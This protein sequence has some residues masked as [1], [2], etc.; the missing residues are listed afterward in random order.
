ML[1]D[2]QADENCANV[3]IL[4]ACSPAACGLARAPSQQA[5]L[6]N[7]LT[8]YLGTASPTHR[9]LVAALAARERERDALVDGA[10]VGAQPLVADGDE[11]DGD[12]GERE[13]EARRDVPRAEDDAGVDDLGVPVSRGAPCEYM[14]PGERVGRER[15]REDWRKDGRT[16]ACSWCISGPCPC[17]RGLRVRRGLRGP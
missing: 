9:S 7:V 4:N 15:E 14:R 2:M 11:D 10:L 16:I 17:P 6:F 1:C 8:W 3:G 12:E 5:G 13:G